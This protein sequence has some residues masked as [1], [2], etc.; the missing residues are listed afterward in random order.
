MFVGRLHNHIPMSRRRSRGKCVLFALCMERKLAE[1]WEN[2]SCA[3]ECNVCVWHGDDD[4]AACYWFHVDTERMWWNFE[5]WHITR[6]KLT[7][8][9]KHAVQQQDERE[10]N[11]SVEL[12]TV[13][14]TVNCDGLKYSNINFL[15]CNFIHPSMHPHVAS[16]LLLLLLFLVFWFFTASSSLLH[17]HTY[18]CCVLYVGYFFFTIK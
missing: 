11:F 4:D 5:L 9:N 18:T 2:S 12:F 7:R 1:N 17:M 6:H 14:I 3:V 13:Y 10:W 8:I 16:F 15:L